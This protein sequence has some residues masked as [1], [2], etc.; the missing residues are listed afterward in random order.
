MD[1]ETLLGIKPRTDIPELRP[2]DTVKVHFKVVEGEKE[3]IQLFQ[4]V[5]IGVQEGG[6]NAS[7]TVRR[8]AYGVGV[9]RKFFYQS[10]RVEKV[11]LVKH[12]KVRRAK[13]Y[14]LRK[15]SGKASRLKEGKA[16]KELELRPEEAAGTQPEVAPAAEAAAPSPQAAAAQPAAEAKAPIAEAK[17]GAK[18]AAPRAKAEA[19]PEVKS[20][21]KAEVRTAPTEAK[22]ETKAE[23]KAQVK[24]EVKA[25][26][27][28]PGVASAEKAEPPSAQP[29]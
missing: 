1:M 6:M 20:E 10:P 18:P 26:A 13:L 22:V 24:A 19:K 25:E 2:G 23:A 8:V 29:T 27:T 17:S 28:T 15:L 5:V 11:E 21:P 12:S 9:E 16:L 4:G 7:F 14:Y 3:R